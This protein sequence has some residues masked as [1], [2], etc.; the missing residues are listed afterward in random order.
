[1]FGHTGDLQIIE[2]GLY[3][4]WRDNIT[5]YVNQKTQLRH[6]SRPTKLVST[7]FRIS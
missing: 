6:L 1:M 4:T 3:F 5:R 2:N 7:K